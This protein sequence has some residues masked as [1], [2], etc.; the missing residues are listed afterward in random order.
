MVNEDLM[1]IGRFAQL[2]GLSIYATTTTS[3]FRPRWGRPDAGLP[4]RP[5]PRGS[6]QTDAAPSR[7]GCQRPNRYLPHRTV[8]PV[9]RR[10]P[11]LAGWPA[12]TWTAAF[13]QL[14]QPFRWGAP[15]RS[16]LVHLGVC[17]GWSG[18]CCGQLGGLWTSPVRR[19][20]VVLFGLGQFV[21]E[22]VL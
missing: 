15:P 5:D 7:P 3:A 14:Q 6:A 4:T 12:D 17:W 1:T 18:A 22:D 16:S 10:H 2:N 9:R 21:A 13:R 20:G 11:S 19:G 8:R